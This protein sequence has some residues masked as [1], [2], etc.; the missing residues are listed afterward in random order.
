M[1]QQTAVELLI[2]HLKETYHLTEETLYELEQAK[3]IEK[4]QKIDFA[5]DFAREYIGFSS[6][7]TDVN[8]LGPAAYYYNKTYGK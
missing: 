5:T 2:E 4:Q 7:C 1:K 3:E 6:V 8:D